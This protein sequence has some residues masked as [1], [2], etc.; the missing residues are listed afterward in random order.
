MF[1]R[2]QEKLDAAFNFKPNI[3]IVDNDLLFVQSPHLNILGYPIELGYQHIEPLPHNFVSVDAFLREVS[4]QLMKRIL[5]VLTQTPYKCIVSKGQ[6]ADEYDLPE[7]CW[8]EAYLPQTRIIPLVD[9]VITH[10]GN[11][12]VTETMAFGRPMIVLPL[13]GDQL[14][15]GTRVHE[16]GYGIRLEPYTFTDNQLLNSLEKLLSDEGLKVK[17]DKTA[18]RMATSNSKEKA[19]LRIEETVDKFKYSQLSMGS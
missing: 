3:K 14:E 5:S 18:K 8:G 12:T 13:F 17:L 4:E 2:Y 9:L 6:R 11:N 1:G 16:T 10:G 7:N 15:N 19:C